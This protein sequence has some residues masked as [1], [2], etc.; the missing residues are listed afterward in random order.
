[1]SLQEF[2]TNKIINPI[3]STGK[4]FLSYTPKDSKTAG[5]LISLIVILAPILL[6]IPIKMGIAGDRFAVYA[7][8]QQQSVVSDSLSESLQI[9]QSKV[10]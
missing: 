9:A 6:H 8:Q 4:P 2:I 3:K 1:M 5:I 10:N 7:Q